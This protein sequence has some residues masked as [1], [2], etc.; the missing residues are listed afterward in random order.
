MYSKSMPMKNLTAE[1]QE[2]DESATHCYVCNKRFSA[3]N[4]KHSD[5]CHITGEYRGPACARCNMNNLS[6]ENMVIP[7]VFHNFSGY[8]SKLLMQHVQDFGY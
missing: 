1:R 7:I 2:R 5:H 4:K 3:D 6:L 8:N